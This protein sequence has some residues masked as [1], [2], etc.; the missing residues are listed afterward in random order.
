MICLW[1]VSGLVV[2]K[3]T[4]FNCHNFYFIK[5]FYFC[6]FDQE[7]GVILQNKVWY[8]QECCWINLKLILA[9]DRI[10]G[11]L[12]YKH[13]QFL[14]FSFKIRS[15]FQLDRSCLRGKTS[16]LIFSGCSDLKLFLS[17]YSNFFTIPLYWR[18]SGIVKKEAK[19]TRAILAFNLNLAALICC[20]FFF[21]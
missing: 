19:H 20:F 10:K 6:S 16:W 4:R 7:M 21:H 15:K 8:E 9:F 14:I 3:H 17:V 11:S 1:V 18:A 5:F 2:L 13:K 12:C